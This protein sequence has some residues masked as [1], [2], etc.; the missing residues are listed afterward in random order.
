MKRYLVCLGLADAMLAGPHTPRSVLARCA[1]AL[2]R[3]PVW[4]AALAKAMIARHSHVWH[5]ASRE[6]L[7]HAI[8]ESP[9]L[10]QAWGAGELLTLRRYFLDAPRMAPLPAGLDHC[11][12]P[13]LPTVGDIAKWLGLEIGD[14]EWLADVRGL[15]AQARD[16]RL[17]HYVYRWVPKRSG[18]HR[19]LEVPKSTL[20]SIQRRIL[21][22]V[23]EYVPTH[24]AV[25][26]FRPRYSCM[27]NARPHVGQEIV[28]RLDLQDFFVSV[29]GM[30]VTA[31]F[32][33]LGYPEQ[34]ARVLAG[35]CT[36]RVPAEVVESRDPAK[37]DFE[38]PQLDWLARKRYRSP[39][40]PQGAPSSPALANL[41]AFRMDLRLHALAE[42]ANARYTRYADDLTFSGGKELARG[43]ERFLSRAGAIA[44][45]EGFSVNFRKTR[46]MRRGVRQQVTGI[47]VN[48][49][50]NVRREDYD[51]LK[52]TLHNC[53]RLGPA[54]QN[55]ERRAD[56]RSHLAG[57]IAH[58]SMLNPERGR[59]LQALFERIEWNGA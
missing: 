2:G 29:R 32:R 59:R 30:K 46:I 39:H 50:P 17:R 48:E 19:L 5:G 35:L 44:L 15:E 52:A 16:S 25:H 55:R 26:G 51:R 10:Y 31:L 21:H 8:E 1:K 18:G 20:R 28:L 38:L 7:A 6:R 34:A 13:D 53:A 45:E 47:V 41:C 36:N 12:L 49:K 27:T 40:L 9:E 23:L 54:G 33:T 24:E 11:V 22:E 57:R 14:L 37:Y 42:S 3:K 4:L 56:F 43:A 58:L